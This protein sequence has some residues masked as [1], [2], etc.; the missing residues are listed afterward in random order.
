MRGAES[1]KE[2]AGKRVGGSSG[3]TVEGKESEAMADMR[4]DFPVDLSPITRIV[5]SLEMVVVVDLER[6]AIVIVTEN[7]EKRVNEGGK[8]GFC[9][10]LSFMMMMLMLFLYMYIEKVDFFFLV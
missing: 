6:N 4:V 1:V 2:L 5:T 8:E 7:R 9:V 10:I 3:G